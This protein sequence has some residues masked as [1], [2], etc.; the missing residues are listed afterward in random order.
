MIFIF[1]S[2][3]SKIDK[4]KPLSL[5]NEID[6]IKD[7]I[8]NCFISY[9]QTENLYQKNLLEAGINNLSYYFDDITIEI[10]YPSDTFNDI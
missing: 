3:S 5:S 6:F 10:K 7:N 4:S 1:D 2:L 8:E 9:D